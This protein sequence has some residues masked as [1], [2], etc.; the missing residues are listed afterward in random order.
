VNLDHLRRIASLGVPVQYGGG[1]RSIGAVDDALLAGAA[2]VILGTAAFTDPALLE[3]A[4]QKHGP[5]RVVVSVDVRRGEVAIEAGPR[6]PMSASGRSLRPSSTTGCR[7]SR[8]RTSTATGC[9]GREF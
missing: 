9:S 3:Q 1:L 4:L 8:T 5:E 7:S 2:R 6:P